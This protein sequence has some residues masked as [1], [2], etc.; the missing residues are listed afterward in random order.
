MSQR[1]ALTPKQCQYVAMVSQGQTHS[2]IARVLGV[3]RKTIIRW[4]QQAHVKSA[5]AEAQA[6]S[7]RGIAQAH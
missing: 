4:S 2:D 1:D 5:I 6:G 7:Q 3:A